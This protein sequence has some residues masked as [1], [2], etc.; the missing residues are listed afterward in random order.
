MGTLLQDLRYAFRMLAKKPG[1][2]A[3][4]VLAIALGIGT[5]TT[6]FSTV[7]ALLL[8]PFNFSTQDRL[9]M[10]WEQNLE[11][12]NVRGSVSPGNYTDWR[13]QSH[14]FEETVALNQHHFNLTEGETPER[15]AGAQVTPNFFK[16]LDVKSEMGRTFSAEE[17]E[18][19]RE[20]VVLL[21]HSLWQRRFAGDKEIVGKS[22]RL[23]GKPY[24]V[25]GVMPDDFEFPLNSSE[26]WVPLAFD[27]KEQV[28]RN[29]NY[30]QVMG[31]LKPGVTL[32]QAQS[33]LRA[34]AERNQQQYPESDAG[35][36]AFVETLNASYTRGSRVYLTVMMGAVAFVLLIA[37][38]NVA[39]LLLV[40]AASR[41]KEMAVRMALGASR[42][43][44][45][46]QL[47]TESLLLAL[48]GGAFGLLLSVWGVEFISKGMP[49][50]FTQYIAGW[51]KLGVDWWVLGFTLLASIVT[52]L[53][54]GLA[55][56]LQATRM[57]LN[58]TL[59]ESSKSSS[60]SLRRNRLRSLLVISEV[61]LSL[62]LSIGAGLMVKSFMNLL[63]TDLGVNPHNVL[64]M[65]LALP[66]IKYKEDKERIN[67]YQELLRRVETLPAVQ[68]VAA[69]NYVP[70]NRGGST[71]SDFRIEGQPAPPGGKRP[72]ADYRVITPQYFE[73][74][75][76]N[77]LQGRAFTERD[78]K[79]A[80]SVV[81]INDTLA[82]KFF[83][84]GDAV[85]KRL[86]ISDEDG[87]LEIV[88]VAASTKDE[89]L[90]EEPELGVYVP[91]MQNPWGSMALVVRTN[92]E[93]TLVTS[94]IRNEVTTLDKDQPIYNVRTMEEVVDES[95]SP[96]RLAMIMFAFFAFVAMF[97]SAIGLY[98]VMS[99]TVAQRTHEIGIRMALG[100]SQKQILKLV[101][102][103]GFILIAI[104]LAL[105]LAGAFAMTRAMSA[106]LYQVSS[107]DP[108][109]FVGVS[110]L[111]T[112]AAFLAC[113]IP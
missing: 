108:L 106:I 14:V 1:F 104:G 5:N 92:S 52:G 88:G 17:G 3:I 56:A 74:I 40:R 111:L 10:L 39:N 102:G 7:N 73:A 8:R 28:D 62:V 101:V 12:G 96:K 24:T 42:W 82:R 20:Q 87:P 65:E 57:N 109:T 100:A 64:T 98:A 32:G 84:R 90:D 55:P 4:A 76:T 110:L 94:A 9:T 6:I 69:V 70:M 99:Y 25:V 21:K 75:G 93:P 11:I 67:F 60:E 29:N 71:S 51:K 43:R 77:V 113:Y 27:P 107:T 49:S 78:D 23:D 33:E 30:L 31:L 80:Q 54:F 22:V 66:R 48:V 61:A 35:K 105:G 34:I 46:R 91:F 18:K 2:T 53:I 85:G 44:L 81:I 112:A 103:Q 72:Y 37:C 13:N 68:K 15:V 19:G 86:I 83:P 38:A 45:I 16:A 47:L 89:D 50:S 26:I 58:E 97:L 41:Q 63:H 95:L 36:T 59:K 79:N